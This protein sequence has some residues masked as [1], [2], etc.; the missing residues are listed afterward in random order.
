MVP[1]REV[2]ALSPPLGAGAEPGA[3]LYEPGALTIDADALALGLGDAAAAHGAELF[4][5]TPV[6]AI[7]RDGPAAVGVRL[8]DRLVK[9]D[10]ILLADDF[11]AIRLIRE[12][13]GRLSLTRDERVALVTAAD[14][15]SIGPALAIGDIRVSRDRTGAVTASG[16]RGGDALARRIVAHAPALAGLTVTAAEPVTAWTGVDGL[17]QVGAAEIPS[18]WLAL[19]FGRDALS[20]ALPAAEC[21][22]AQIAGRRCAVRLRALRADAPAGRPFSGGRAMTG[23]FRLPGSAPARFGSAIDRT[24]P[25]GFRVGGRALSGLYGDTLA[26]ALMAS[27]VQIHGA[28]PLLGRPRGPMALGM[29]DALMR[30]LEGDAGPFAAIA[31]SGLVLREGLRAHGGDRGVGQALRRFSPPAG[32]ET[33]TLPAAQLALERLR[34]ALPLPGPR[35]PALA[36]RIQTKHESC[37]VVVIGAG[38]AGLSAAAALRSAGLDVRVIEASSRAGGAADLYEGRI[39]GRPLAGLGDG[40]SRRAP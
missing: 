32:P 1:G 23:P 36:P 34:R 35:L 38:L 9:A 5:F 22:A 3:A 20:L 2:A 39:D 26:S 25:I 18:L 13:K 27:G 16:P 33:R 15:P 14:A 40:Q 10:A 28:S 8:D 11:A 17:P 19:G 24:E 31:S 37:A 6:T 12:G 7:E 21:L 30:S 29:E 4:A